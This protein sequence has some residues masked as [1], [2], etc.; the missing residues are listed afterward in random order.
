MPRNLIIVFVAVLIIIPTAFIAYKLLSTKQGTTVT[1]PTQTT[2][3][4]D[5]TT[6]SDLTTDEELVLSS[7]TQENKSEADTKRFQEALARAAVGSDQLDIT[8]C[9][10]NPTILR[11]EVDQKLTVKNNDSNEHTLVVNQKTFS[12]SAKDSSTITTDFGENER[13]YPYSCDQKT[14]AGVI[15]LSK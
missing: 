11:I 12:I 14:L 7:I 3:T 8:S 9:K 4:T 2:P 5:Q 13:V 15:W 1:P 6:S 10:S